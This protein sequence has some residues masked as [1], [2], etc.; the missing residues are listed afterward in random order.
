MAHERPSNLQSNKKDT[1]KVTKHLWN[2]TPLIYRQKN[3]QFMFGF[4]YFRLLFII[5]HV[6]VDAAD[7]ATK[8]TD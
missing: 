6:S 4:H 7:F 8:A 5:E 2:R 3:K 1:K